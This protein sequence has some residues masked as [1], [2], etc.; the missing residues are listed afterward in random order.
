MVEPEHCTWPAEQRL[1]QFEAQE[2]DTQVWPVGQALVV[3]SKQRSG[4][5]LQ[6][7]RFPEV[8]HC[9]LSGK[10]VL[11]QLGTHEPLLQTSGEEH[12]EAFQP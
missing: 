2:P 10:Q 3:Q 9:V 5:R 4:W 12:G 7:C 1:V 6:V 8:S 11:V